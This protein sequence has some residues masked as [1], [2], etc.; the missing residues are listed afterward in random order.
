ME[1]YLLEDLK[2]LVQH[3]VQTRLKGD[4][5]WGLGAEIRQ[6]T[7]VKRLGNSRALK[8]GVLVLCLLTSDPRE[9]SSL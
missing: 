8:Q 7:D 2:S 5:V 4:L 1:N 6:F 9:L 3:R